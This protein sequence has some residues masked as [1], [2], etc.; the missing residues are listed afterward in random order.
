MTRHELREHIFLLVFR[1]EFYSYEDMPGQVQMYIEDME[2]P[3]DEADSEYI[4]KKSADI[5][6]RLKEI[7]EI[8]DKN[9]DKWKSDRMGKVELAVLRLAVYEILFDEDIPG[10]VAI[11]EAVELA[12]KYGQDSSGSFVNGVLAKV[13]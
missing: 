10:K 2:E 1:L 5:F 3:A 9:A 8:I 11:D 7:D 12:K 4:Q 6:L 13:I